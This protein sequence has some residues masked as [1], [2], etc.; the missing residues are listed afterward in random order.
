MAQQNKAPAINVQNSMQDL[1]AAVGEW[2]IG[3]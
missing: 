1:Y 2:L 3:K